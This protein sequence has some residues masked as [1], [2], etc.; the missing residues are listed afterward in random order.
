MSKCWINWIWILRNGNVR[1]ITNVVDV[2]IPILIFISVTYIIFAT[3]IL[4]TFGTLVRFFFKFVWKENFPIHKN[5]KEFELHFRGFLKVAEKYI[6]SAS[7]CQSSPLRGPLEQFWLTTDSTTDWWTKSSDQKILFYIDLSLKKKKCQRNLGYILENLIPQKSRNCYNNNFTQFL[8]YNIFPSHKNGAQHS[9]RT[10]FTADR[11]TKF[12]GLLEFGN[13]WI[14]SAFDVLLTRI[15]FFYVNGAAPSAKIGP[16][17]Q[18]TDWL[19]RYIYEV[20][21]SK[22]VA[23]IH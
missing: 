14:G 23:S 17:D 9:W 4:L 10:D 2:S 5:V 13:K 21:S 7:K 11:W 12:S 6:F 3:F 8:S 18:M 15:S 19:L 20:A 1:L 22:E 16:I